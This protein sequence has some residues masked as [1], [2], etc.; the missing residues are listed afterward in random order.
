MEPKTG[1]IFPKRR[2]PSSG[3]NLRKP[4]RLE[5]H[6]SL[7]PRLNL[8][9]GQRWETLRLN[10]VL[11]TGLGPDLKGEGT[12]PPNYKG[13]C[14]SVGLNGLVLP[15]KTCIAQWAVSAVIGP[16]NR[17]SIQRCFLFGTSF[18]IRFGFPSNQP[19]ARPS[20]GVP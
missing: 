13:R 5:A 9:K 17:A 7:T 6:S 2:G 18:C 3:G 8:W 11:A 16:Q 4:Y 12:Q 10:I 15:C 1:F 19:H 20:Q 14:K